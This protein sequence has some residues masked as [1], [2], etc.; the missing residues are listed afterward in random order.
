MNTE[1]WYAAKCIFFHQDLPDEQGRPMYEERV[2]LLKADN[3]EQAIQLAEED[4]NQYA[5]DLDGCEYCGYL[6]V[7]HLYDDEVGHGTE[8][9]SLIRSSS[10][11]INDYVNTF[12]DTG[13][14]RTGGAAEDEEGNT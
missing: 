8:V 7:F 13:T 6:D 5:S 11:G 9:Y 14:E 12:Y 10:L 1:P 4:A 2:V 3:F